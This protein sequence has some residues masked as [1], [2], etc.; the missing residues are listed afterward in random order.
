[1]E[2][3]EQESDSVYLNRNK[4]SFRFTHNLKVV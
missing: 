4:Y 3:Y 2:D 1:M